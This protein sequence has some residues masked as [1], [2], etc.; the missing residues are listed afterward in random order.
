MYKIITTSAIASLLVF[1]VISQAKAQDS[2]EILKPDKQVQ[3]IYD[4][5]FANSGLIVNRP[6]FVDSSTVMNA[7]TRGAT[8]VV[9]KGMLN[10]TLRDRNQDMLAGVLAH[11]LAHVV[12]NHP[13]KNNCHDTDQG[14]RICE[15]EADRLG[16]KI[17]VDSGYDCNE[18]VQYFV[19][20][21]D[22]WGDYEEEKATHPSLRNRAEHIKTLCKIYKETGKLPEFVN[23]KEPTSGK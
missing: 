21:I 16:V 5:L 11:E 9:H 15:T 8:V 7:Y 6:L 2:D 4:N 17:M 1:A 14:S 12:L 23:P 10:F 22:K 13:Y 3:E 19:D 20:Q 18:R